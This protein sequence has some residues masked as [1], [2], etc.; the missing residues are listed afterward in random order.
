MTSHLEKPLI[1]VLVPLYNAAE[2]IL[3]TLRSILS[4]DFSN[5]E[6]IVVDD[7]SKDASFQLVRDFMA[8]QNEGRIK[9]FKNETNLGPEGN[10]NKALSLATGKY[11]KLVC[12]DDTL[13]PGALSKQV[14]IFENPENSGLSLV[15]GS[16]IVINSKG[17]RLGK[18]GNLKGGRLSSMVAMKQVIRAGTNPLGEPAAGMFIRTDA[19]KI[20][21]Y[22]FYSP[23]AIDVDFWMRLLQLGDLWFVPEA[24]STFRISKESC[25]SMIGLRQSKD[26]RLFIS[27]S[28]QENPLVIRPIDSII[29]S[30]KSMVLGVL[31]VLYFK[32]F[33]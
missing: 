27:R 13:E 20:G 19:Q 11:I 33:A 30:F 14:A 25:S 5:I 3:E 12:S 9:L 21:G 28:E 7:C 26:F 32:I 23:Y 2:Y 29:G 16:R 24:I 6:V 31:R 1:S 18:R 22:R 17:I 15:A 8:T 4:Q 10:W